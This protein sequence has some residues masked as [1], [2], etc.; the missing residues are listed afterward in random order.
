MIGQNAHNAARDAVPRDADEE[1]RFLEG[2]EAFRGVA[3]ILIVIFHAYQYTREGTG[4]AQYLYEGTVLHFLFNNLRLT[5]WFFVLTGFLLFLPVARAALAQRVP[6]GVS[7]Y[8]IRWAFRV[9]PLYYVAIVV[10]WTWRYFGAPE[11]RT[12]LLQHLTFTQVFSREHIF[13]TIGP[14]WTLAIEVIFFLFVAILGPLVYLACGRLTS[15]RSRAAALAG[16]VGAL[17]L[18]SVLYKGWARYLAGIP[19]DNFPAYFG[20]LAS[21]DTFA[22]GMLLAVV[23]A[24]GR[25]CLG[26]D[27]STR[28]SFGGVALVLLTFVFSGNEA[29]F[30]YVH[31]VSGAAFLMVLAPVVLGPRDWSLK[32]A[33]DLPGARYLGAISYGIFLWHEPLMI[34]LGKRE[35]LI[36]QAPNA[37]PQNALVLV[38]LS[39]AVAA[40]S[41]RLLERPALFLRHLFDHGGRRKGRL[42][43]R[44]PEW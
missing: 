29:V 35:F 17:F 22:M 6:R 8:P 39:I 3:A 32:R 19:E 30:L 21:L 26:R 20:P 18:F 10:V 4:A 5:E 34:E 31:T 11:Q 41:E 25:P 23:A 42:S 9:L 15:E 44:R 1:R 14:S 24:Y 37:F 40:L 13:W 16:I 7:E 43:P 27:A 36:S 2:L 33:V 28:L 38:A 12:D